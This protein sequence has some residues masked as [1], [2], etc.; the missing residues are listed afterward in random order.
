MLTCT[1]PV[2]CKPENNSFEQIL[3]ALRKRVIQFI[4]AYPYGELDDEQRCKLKGL[5]EESAISATKVTTT[6]KA[7]AAHDGEVRK[8]CHTSMTSCCMQNNGL[9]E[10]IS[11]QN[12]F[13]SCGSPM[14]NDATPEKSSRKSACSVQGSS[15]RT[16]RQPTENSDATPEKSPNKLACPVQ[17]S[18][19]RKG[20]Q[21]TEESRGRCAEGGE[22]RSM[23]ASSPK[24][25]MRSR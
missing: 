1:V 17:G 7:A 5:M 6:D 15:K 13:E 25:R 12:A 20:R 14:A 21:P 19:K 9:L 11:L 4:L 16:G 2:I 10:C 8:A 18:T 3:T 22:V 24:K 23:E